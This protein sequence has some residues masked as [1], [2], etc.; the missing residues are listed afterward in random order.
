MT[1]EKDIRQSALYREAAALY[2]DMRRP[3]S[4]Q[5]SD[6]AEI[7]CSPDAKRA[8]FSGALVE[9]LDGTP[10]TRICEVEFVTGETRVLTFGPNTDRCPKYSPDGRLIAFLSDRRNKGN[11]Q[12][13]LLDA[14]T[15]AAI[16]T[17]PV[18][19]WV[20]YL[21]WSPDGG[22]ILLA[23]A[24]HGADIP[25]EQGAVTSKQVGT[26]F[27]SWIPV[28]EAGEENFRWRHAW[29]YTLAS[30]T[31]RRV[32]GSRENIWEAVWCGNDAIVSV[33][34]L[35]PSEGMWY[36]ARLYLID[37]HTCKSR[38]IYTPIAQLG[39]P[40]ACPA[41]K[42]IAFVEAVCSD[43]WVVAGDLKLI[44]IATGK[45]QRVDTRDIDITHTEW[46]SDR[47]LL[48]AGHRSFETAVGL[49]HLEHGSFIEAWS[50]REVTA[51]GRYIRVSG[52]RDRGDCVMIGEGFLRAPEVALISGGTYRTVR[53]FDLGCAEAGRT[54]AAA[55]PITWRAS[56]GLELQ[57]WLVM[58]HGE[59][60]H[61]LILNIHGG[62][63]WQWRPMWLGRNGAALLMLLKRGFAVFFPNPR[64]SSGRGQEFAGCVFGDMGGAETADHLSG[65]DY[66][67]SAGIADPKRLGVTGASHG[68]FMTSWI[69]AQDPRFAAAVPVAPVTNW[70]SEH[71]ISNLSHFC[72]ISLNDRYTNPLG[73]YFQ[74]SPILHA[75]KVKT[76]T[77]NICGALDRATPP[78]EAMQ[79]H[80]VLLQNGVKSVLV[81]YPEEGHGVRSFPAM[82]DYAAR[83]VG[84]FEK[85]ISKRV[86]DAT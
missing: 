57:G 49:F 38:E 83:I 53:S 21:H 48:V 17:P 52:V 46:R 61:A 58:P 26:Q 74:R 12:L 37:I 42:H 62:P 36:S 45:V 47:V 59:A 34:S 6:A 70:V 71:L 18:E 81:T 75:D 39:W 68:G 7:N 22:R 60:P 14:S 35:G 24:G 65:I 84:W 25:S 2:E 85:H 11:F 10:T 31:V 67:V 43:R 55:D 4:G 33:T 82:I 29:V 5:I 63:I 27:P 86:G 66:L 41:G 3:G 50:S 9:K 77:L 51:S 79:F 44:E 28:V 8:A 19:G 54:V 76:P 73:S 1:F 16:D 23:V 20:E 72:E 32:S 78:T 56:D 40:S 64:G 15:G 13:Y 80:N 30:N 69:I